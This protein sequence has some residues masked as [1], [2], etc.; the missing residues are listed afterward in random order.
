[1]DLINR[2]HLHILKLPTLGAGTIDFSLTNSDAF[3][4]VDVSYIPPLESPGRGPPLSGEFNVQISI[5][6]FKTD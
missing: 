1:M 4:V 3:M 6:P 5:A 2:F